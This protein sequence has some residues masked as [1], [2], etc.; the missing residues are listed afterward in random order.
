[1]A[2]KVPINGQSPRKPTND[3]QV[4]ALEGRHR[5]Q[6]SLVNE[7]CV[8]EIEQILVEQMMSPVLKRLI[9]ENCWCPFPISAD[10][11]DDL[12]GFGLVD[13][14]LD[15]DDQRLVVLMF[16]MPSK[17]TK[18]LSLR[19]AS[20]CLVRISSRSDDHVFYPDDAYNTVSLRLA[21]RDELIGRYSLEQLQDMKTK[22]EEAI[23]QNVIDNA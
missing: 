2:P 17:L 23:V 21:E 10:D 12:F 4:E 6:Q 20:E 5:M 22:V 3:K 14:Q 7:A 8:R 1:M 11:R 13:A 15:G 9:G 16:A 19:L 18:A